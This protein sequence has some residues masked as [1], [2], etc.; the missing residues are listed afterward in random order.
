GVSMPSPKTA[1]V[2]RHLVQF[3]LKIVVAILFYYMTMGVLLALLNHPVSRESRYAMDAVLAIG[4]AVMTM[5]LGDNNAAKIDIPVP[6]GHTLDL[7]LTGPAAVFI[8]VFLVAR[9]YG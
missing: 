9:L 8:S 1:Q 4:A 5:F 2:S 6:K 7:N 3:G